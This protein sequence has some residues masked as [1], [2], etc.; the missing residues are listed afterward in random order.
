MEKV[1]DATALILLVVLCAS[2]G[3]QQVAIQVASPGVSPILQTGIFCID[4]VK[5]L[6]MHP[7]P[8]NRLRLFGPR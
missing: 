2:W 4:D 7:E 5:G 8:F 3:L 6:R 1:N